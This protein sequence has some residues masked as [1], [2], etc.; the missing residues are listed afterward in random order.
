MLGT[1]AH[2]SQIPV[3]NVDCRSERGLPLNT[4]S[5]LRVAIDET[6]APPGAT[7]LTEREATVEL[8]QKGQPLPLEVISLPTACSRIRSR[9]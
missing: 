8:R 6:A 1:A 2:S 9:A 3:P 5:A 7:V 4:D